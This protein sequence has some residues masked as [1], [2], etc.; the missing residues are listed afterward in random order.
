MTPEHPPKVPR[1][2][3]GLSTPI[4]GYHGQVS[5]GPAALIPTPAS[6]L[7][8]P[9]PMVPSPSIHYRPILAPGTGTP[10]HPLDLEQ[11]SVDLDQYH[12]LFAKGKGEVRV[13][14]DVGLTRFQA[15]TKSFRNAFDLHIVRMTGCINYLSD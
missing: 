2:K 12:W 13:A 8:S 6:W 4:Q 15:A 10:S 14:V 11:P 9:N 1:H 7:L 3:K 5:K